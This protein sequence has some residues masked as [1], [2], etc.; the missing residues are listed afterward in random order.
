MKK[1]LLSSILLLTNAHSLSHSHEEGTLIN[2]NHHVHNKVIEMTSTQ[3]YNQLQLFD[4]HLS[5][6]KHHYEIDDSHDKE[7]DNY[8]KGDF[9]ANHIWQLVYMINVKINTFRKQHNLPR[10]EEVGIEPLVDMKT[11][12]AYGMIKRQLAEIEIIRDLIDI[13]DKIDAPVYEKE[14]NMTDVFNKL[15]HVSHELDLLINHKITPSTV[16]SQAMRL[17]KDVSLVLQSLNILDTQL[18]DKKNENLTPEDAFKKV[19]ELISH[20]QK[21]QIKLG[22]ERTDF[23]GLKKEIIEPEDTFIAIQMALAEFQS[24]KA[25]LGLTTNVTAPSELYENKT[26][27]DVEQL[28][29]LIIKRVNLIQSQA[30]K[31]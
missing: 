28:I 23:N 3:L 19:M 13:K 4:A 25:V 1:Y 12:L 14:K 5:A 11:N 27:S 30:L 8:T 29:E 15:L 31:W 21:I 26:P 22:L 7:Y 17:Y 6:F 10:I 24:I 16:F 2:K 9:K 20:I 18:P